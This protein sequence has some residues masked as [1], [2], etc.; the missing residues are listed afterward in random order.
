MRMAQTEWYKISHIYS[1]YKERVQDANVFFSSR[2]E[3]NNSF[4]HFLFLYLN[5]KF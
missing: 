4:K 1:L 2:I 3:N 5:L